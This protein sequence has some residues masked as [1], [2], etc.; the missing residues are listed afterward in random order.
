MK[1]NEMS[2]TILENGPY[3]VKGS[4]PLSIV[5]VNYDEN[6]VPRSYTELKK[7]EVNEEYLLC[8][9]GKS[10]S[11]P[12]CDNAHNNFSFHGRETAKREITWRKV[13]GPE[14]VLY[15]ALDFCF[16][17][18]FC[19]LGGNTWQMIEKSD[20]A[21]CKQLGIEGAMG[22][23]AGRLV[24]KDKKTNEILEPDYEPSIFII[25]DEGIKGPIWVRGKIPIISADGETYP[26]RNR[27]T[28]CRCGKSRNKPFCDGM[29]N[30]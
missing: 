23:P 20:N 2:I 18:T 22:C 19:H 12:F 11:Y 3:L 29:H 7:F 26:I 1:K 28:L 30:Y 17:A 13:D 8:R 25:E 9:C 14:L 15:D 21:T 27:V 6:D 24:V 4:V 16:G 5:Q 10:S